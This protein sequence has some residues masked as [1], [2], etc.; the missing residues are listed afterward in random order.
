[1]HSMCYSFDK[2]NCR[3][4][5]NKF[6]GQKPH[7]IPDIAAIS[8]INEFQVDIKLCR[9]SK[10]IIDISEITLKQATSDE[11]F[12]YRIGMITASTLHEV[13]RKVDKHFNFRS[14]HAANNL[15]ARICLYT[16]PVSSAVL[17]WERNK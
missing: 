1:M 9:T 15:C 12:Q 7:Y 5:R 8:N 11:W 10:D 13:F 4:L 17:S 3:Q 6:I 2:Q 16:K 14:V